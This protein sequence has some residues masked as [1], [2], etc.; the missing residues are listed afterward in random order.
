[1]RGIIKSRVLQGDLLCL[2]Q[3]DEVRC[4]DLFLLLLQH[5]AQHRINA[6]CPLCFRI[7]KNEPVV[8]RFDAAGNQRFLGKGDLFADPGIVQRNFLRVR[9]KNEV[10]SLHDAAVLGVYLVGILLLRGVELQ[11]VAGLSLIAVQ[12]LSGEHDL[13]RGLIKSRVL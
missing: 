9:Q 4:H 7:G 8:R 13:L 12:L 11:D 3:R 6:V 5:S 2:L 10:V 1:M